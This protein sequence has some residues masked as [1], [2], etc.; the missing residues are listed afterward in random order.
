MNRIKQRS[1][2]SK[3][4]GVCFYK[5]DITWRVRIM[6]GGKMNSLGSFDTEK[7]AAAKYNEAAIELFGEHAC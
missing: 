6:L 7:Q 3:F 4:K 2:S 1:T 5:R